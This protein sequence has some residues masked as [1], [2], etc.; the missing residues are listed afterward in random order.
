MRIPCSLLAAAA[1]LLTCTGLPASDAENGTRSQSVPLGF[2][3]QS[4]ATQERWEKRLQSSVS[5][6]QC[7]TY[8]RQLTRE[9]HVA[10]TPG[11]RR[12]SEF[13]YNEFRRAGLEAE[14][15]EY[16]VLLSYPRKVAVEL[17]EPQRVKLAN[18]EPVIKGDNDT[19][20]S[21]PLA[22]MPWNGYSPSADLT[23]PVVYVNYGRAEDYDQL[24]AR[25]ISV[26]G[27]IVLARYF[28]G[29]RGGKSLE[30]E[31][32]GAA[33]IIVYSD[34]AEDG[35][36]RGPV[37][38]NGPWGPLEHF[39]RGA[40]VYDFNSPGDPLTP[41]W[42]SIESAK[43]LNEADSKILPKIPMVPLSGADAQEILKHIGGPEAPG[44]WQGKLPLNYH[45]G[46]ETA[47]V[48]LAL[49]MENR[50]TPIWDVI[51]RIPGAE[52]PEKVVLLGNHHDAWVYG[53]VDPSS[54][55]ATMLE[56]ARVLGRMVKEGFRPRRTIVLGNWD[57]EEYTLTGSTEWGEEHSDDLRKNA[58]VCL[59][60]DASASG[61][62]F[63]VSAVPSLVPAIIEATQAVKDPATGR[64]VY[65]RWKERRGDRSVRSYA[66]EGSGAAEVP[67]GLL[68]GGSDYMVFLQHLGVPSLDMIFDGPYGV[69]H[70]VYDDFQWMDRFGDRGFKYH[71]AMSRLW[72]VLA[73][74]FANAD[75]LPLDYSIYAA[76]IAAYL[77]GL[78]KLTPPDFYASSIRPLVAKCREWHKVA[79]PFR[80]AQ[81]A[82][83]KPGA[84][85][86]LNSTLMAQERALLDD[87]G[88]PGRPWFKHLIY[89]PLPSYDAVTLPGLREAIE[90]G[91]WAMAREQAARL[92]DALDRAIAAAR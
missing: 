37:Y 7:R 5:P 83:L 12:L 74:R 82:G 52:E 64:S 36:P 85:S 84:T 48:R 18:P 71:A 73:L 40:V 14:I 33:A 53:A 58:V 51:A 55:T 24:E 30:A 67:F 41:G 47:K 34:P 46:G 66:V 26:R 20:I 68:G 21:D 11:D 70:S 2:N 60:V 10:G 23:L 22:R 38:P 65:D 77:E 3:K 19:R 61:Q 49:D 92:G 13:I 69:Y 75:V 1:L 8:L 16:R 39:Q 63:S 15:V 59:N 6:K 57:A 32:R 42:A 79:P 17:V 54:G 35:A 28:H 72:G 76:E 9:P 50:V 87:R 27:K 25:G 45:L 29:Y 31:R 86:S 43:R 62:D 81:D 78:E 89:A 4:F 91:D 88:L 80:A 56:L 44:D 90:K